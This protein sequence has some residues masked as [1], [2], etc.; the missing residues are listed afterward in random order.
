MEKK[1]M[2]VAFATWNNRIAPV[3]DVAG[4]LHIVEAESGEIILSDEEFLPIDLLPVQKA[5]RLSEL[6][7]KTLICGAISRPLYDTIVASGI[8]VIPFIAGELD[9]V[10]QVWLSGNPDW[11]LFAMPGCCGRRTR[12]QGGFK[13]NYQEVSYMNGSGRGMGRGASQ[14]RQGQRFGR[15]GGESAAG[16]SGNCVCPQCGHKEPHQR[17]IPCFEQ[18]CPQCGAAMARE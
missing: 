12:W 16:P 17:G 15:M 9:E 7:V 5:E 2:K 3:F 10:V 6:G 18:K 1:I 4:L 14:R 13:T 11:H 8:E